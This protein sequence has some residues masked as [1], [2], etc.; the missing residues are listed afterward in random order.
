MKKVIWFLLVLALVSVIGLGI[1][2]NGCDIGP[3]ETTTTVKV[4]TTVAPTS[5]TTTAGSTTTSST[6]TTTFAPPYSISGTVSQGSTEGFWTDWGTLMVAVS[7]DKFNTFVDHGTIFIPIATGETSAS[8]EITGI[9]PGTTEVYLLSVLYF[10]KNE[11]ALQGLPPVGSAIG[12]YADGLMGRFGMGTA[13]PVTLVHDL[14]GLNWQTN[15]SMPSVEATFEGTV[16]SNTMIS[17]APGIN[18]L[19]VNASTNPDDLLGS[20]RYS[21]IEIVPS[22]VSPP[23]NVVK[24]YKINIGEQGSYYIWA[25]LNV[26]TPEARAPKPNDQRGEYDDGYVP[27]AMLGWHL[28]GTSESA[29]IGTPRDVTNEGELQDSLDFELKAV[30]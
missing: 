1:L 25:T 8:F 28:A 13:E 17:L 9:D 30:R 18:T 21:T 27:S 6:T 3:T 29:N 5:T 26:N 19:K 24:Q 22:P 10:G 11:A 7:T 4:T 20:I 14:T 2:M 12:Q 23:F 16:T 15:L